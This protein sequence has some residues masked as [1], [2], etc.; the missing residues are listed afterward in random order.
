M[1]AALTFVDAF[2][3]VGEAYGGGRGEHLLVR[4]DGY[5]GWMGLPDRLAEL[6]VYLERV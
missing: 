2:G 5:I 1:N 6:Q 4:P 3:H